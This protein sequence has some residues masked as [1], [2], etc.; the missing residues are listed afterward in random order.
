[1]SGLDALISKFF[2][3]LLIVATASRPA[4]AQG[5]IFET[6]ALNTGLG[7]MPDRIDR[8]TPGAT[9]VSFLRAADAE[10][11]TAA[12]H[13]LD[14][15]DLPPS[16]RA[17]EGRAWFTTYTT[18]L[19]ATPCWT[20]RPPLIVPTLCKSRA[21]TPRPLPAIPAGRCFCATCPLTWPRWRSG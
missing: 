11:W 16:R 9:M 19:T 20:G 13:L 17:A 1:M 2:V 3:I 14:L 18:F 10:D 6:P 21:A 15:G 8:N 4:L 7:F 5:A 12:A